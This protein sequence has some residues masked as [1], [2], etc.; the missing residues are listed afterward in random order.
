[1]RY[2]K[3]RSRPVRQPQREKLAIS[4]IITTKNEEANLPACLS[5]LTD[6]SQIIVVDSASSDN[7]AQIAQDHGALLVAY[8]WDGKYPKKRQYCLDHLGHLIKHD[9]VFFV[10]ADEIVTSKLIAEL[11]HVQN[12][13]SAQNHCGYFVKGRYIWKGKPLRFGMHNNK[14]A[15]LNRYEMEFPTVNDLDIIPGMGEIEGHYQPVK[16]S[17]FSSRQIGQIKAP[18][19]HDACTNMDKWQE[20][21]A[22]YAHWEQ[23]MDKR[24]AWPQEISQNRKFIK[25][26]FR[27]APKWLRGLIAFTHSYILKAGFLDGYR[28]FTFACLRMSYYWR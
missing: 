28:G 15:L 5:A 24:G 23:E 3:R 6:F 7:T 25:R 18:L 21:H 9:W 4:A 27:R 19:L 2:K 13:D 12:T 26:L 11:Y 16:K 1:M 20:R 14:L 17:N 10:D 22:R 8:Q